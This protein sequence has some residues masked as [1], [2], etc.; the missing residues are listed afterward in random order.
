[1]CA[2]NRVTMGPWGL[3]QNVSENVDGWS[4]VSRR[5][6]G[7]TEDSWAPPCTPCTPSINIPAW[8]KA[9]PARDPVDFHFPLVAASGN[10]STLGN[11]SSPGPQTPVPLSAL[12]SAEIECSGSACCHQDGWG[13]W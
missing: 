13:A 3:N 10:C 6:E 12:V 7:L 2:Q 9:G 11:V 5:A 4:R 8:L 1:M